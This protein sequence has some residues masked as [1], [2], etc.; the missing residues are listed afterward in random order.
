MGNQLGSHLG[1]RCVTSPGL[2]STCGT[3]GDGAQNEGSSTRCFSP[4]GVPA[5]ENL[6]LGFSSES[7]GF[8]D[9]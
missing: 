4:Q 8:K 3:K 1:E 6:F 2:L 7:T 9:G 5:R